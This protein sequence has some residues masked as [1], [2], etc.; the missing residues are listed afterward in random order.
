MR[1][2]K[3]PQ[4]LDK[5]Q[6]D[7][8]SRRAEMKMALTKRT[9][10]REW[11]VPG[12]VTTATQNNFINVPCFLASGW[13]T[14]DPPTPGIPSSCPLSHV[15]L[16]IPT[17][18]LRSTYKSLARPSLVFP[19]YKANWYQDTLRRGYTLTVEHITM[20]G[21]SALVYRSPSLFW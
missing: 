20:L 17:H 14:C 6:P 1:G 8:S 5:V 13:H 12:S 10:W 21:R 9:M 3:E 16:Q 7:S 11:G 2:E 15:F 18:P 19:I 4:V